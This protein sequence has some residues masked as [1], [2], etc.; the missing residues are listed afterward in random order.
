MKIVFHYS[1]GPALAARL[2]ALPGLDVTVCPEDDDVGFAAAMRD[3]DVL[4]H[5][6]KRCSAEVIAGAPKLR[7]IQKIGVGVN[8]I[9]LAAAA[10]RG[11]PV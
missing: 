1:A 5:V 7:L 3:A 4:W 2:R 6:L 11:I 8:T 10:R 9:D